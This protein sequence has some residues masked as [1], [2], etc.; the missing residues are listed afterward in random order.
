MTTPPPNPS[1]PGPA[2]NKHWSPAEHEP[3]VLERWSAARVGAADPATVLS[4]RKKPYVMFI[5]P[6][7]VTAALHLGHALNNTLQDILARAHRMMGFETLWM[8]G[9]DH[10]GIATQAVVERRLMKDEKK[11]RTDYRREDFIAKVQAFK[12]EYEATITGQLKVMGC[13]CD[14]DRQRFTMDPQ[15]TGAVREAFF[16]LFRDGL[17]YRGKRLVNWDPVLLT[18]LADDEVNME[19]V[20]GTFFYLRY[21]LVD[22]SG[23]PVLW[24]VLAGRGMLLPAGASG[25]GPAWVTVATT[26][27]ETYLGD[28]AVA[29]NP[30]DPRAQALRGLFVKLPLVERII[31]IVED[32]Y[33]VMP[34]T[35][36]DAPGVDAKAK[37]A[38]GV[39]KVT[40]AHDP[41]D[42][43]IGRRHTLPVIN[44]M[45]PDAS[46]SDKHGWSDIGGA[47]Q[48]VGMSREIARREVVNQF[49]RLGLLEDRRPYRHSVGHSDRSHAPIEPYLSDQWYVRVTDDRLTGA[50][51]RAM[52]LDQR[53]TSG[54]HAAIALP[55]S[56]AMGDG[57]L[58]FH[59]ERYAR[60]FQHWHENLRDW[61]ISRQLWWG[62][63]IP[64]WTI[65]PDIARTKKGEVIEDSAFVEDM[66]LAHVAG[67]LRVFFQACGIENE[68]CF[69]QEERDTWRVCARSERAVRA[70]AALEHYTQ[71][72]LMGELG[73]TDPVTGRP[74]DLSVKLEGFPEATRAAADLAGL[75]TVCEQESDVLDTWF[76]SALWPLST[77]GWPLETPE[78]RAFNPSSS[79]CTA[80]EII[81]LWVS[82]MVMFNRY[83]RGQD[84]RG[85]TGLDAKPHADGVLPFRDVFI[86]A[87]VQDEQGRKMSKSLG[88]GVDPLDIIA[89][90]GADALRFTLCEMTTHTQ[91]VRMPVVRDAKTGRNG[92][93]RFDLGRNFA[94]KLWN[95]SKLVAMTFERAAAT[96]PGT[97]DPGLGLA[98]RWMLSRLAAAT[99]ACERAL[100]TYSFS[101][102]AQTLYVLLW[103]DYCD[104]YLEA[105]KPTVAASPAQ[106]GVMLHVLRVILRLMHPVMPFITEVVD[107]SLGRLAAP[108]PTGI[109]FGA[110]GSAVLALAPWPSVSE[111]LRDLAVEER[112]G[113]LRVVVESVR[114]VRAKMNLARSR[115]I[116]LHAPAGLAAEIA[117][118]GGITET[119]AALDRVTT[120][121][122]PERSV[123]LPIGEMEIHLSGLSDSVDAGAERDR[124]AKLV[125]ECDRSVAALDAR[126][127]N[128][129]YADKAP[130]KLVE[131]SRRQRAAK[132]AERDAAKAALERLA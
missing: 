59:P 49:T 126:L 43:E 37:F 41:N 30:K 131:E 1:T 10:A 17:I 20:D 50:A 76:S 80:R 102:Y 16:R 58:R 22:R 104:W 4:G 62:H 40:P 33:V 6:P 53:A 123:A 29:V 114:E 84:A 68:A 25:M 44:V 14:W 97:P 87:M 129:G 94:T 39:L 121:Q 55:K 9:T 38:T 83:F 15:C 63:R 48:F 93:P 34:A 77:L 64:I 19:E 109:G 116:T 112:F 60:T 70:F 26:R 124:L 31:P 66:F 73:D 72:R 96:P 82:R 46:I 65:I 127:N 111:T 100:R 7:N 2:E 54:D 86:H 118:T 35:D 122:A 88:N 105:V 57:L 119:L 89:T 120:E 128:P 132:V 61:C 8:P 28:T 74:L 56:P 52:A 13:S 117:G 110:P 79:L 103:N 32:D 113:R 36:P 95:A 91:D 18:A 69:L 108:V 12:D 27:P 67:H 125:A 24:S 99:A 90:H 98:D 5:P 51:L 21:P 75:I 92:S 81:T 115:K 23:A 106:Q 42:Y 45:A 3:R 78:L 107:E 130:A 47:E 85:Q 101:E 11:R 71:K